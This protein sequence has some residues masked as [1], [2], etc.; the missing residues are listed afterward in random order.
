[1]YFG[2]ALLGRDNFKLL[3]PSSSEVEVLAVVAG[4]SPK[5]LFRNTAGSDAV[6][7]NDDV[8]CIASRYHLAKIK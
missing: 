3:S 1:M 8:T 7:D 4:H 2:R 5:S 6:N